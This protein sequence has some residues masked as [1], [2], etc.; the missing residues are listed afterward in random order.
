[1]IDFQKHG[2]QLCRKLKEA[3]LQ[4]YYTEFVGHCKN[5]GCSMSIKLN[6]MHS[7]AD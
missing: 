5:L 4:G 1:M 3:R 7:Q 2:G 6:S